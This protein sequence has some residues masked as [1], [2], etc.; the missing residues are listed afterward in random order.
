MKLVD[1]VVDIILKNIVSLFHKTLLPQSEGARAPFGN[2]A[3]PC[4]WITHVLRVL[5]ITESLF[6]FQLNQIQ[7]SK[8]KLKT[9]Y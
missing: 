8:L 1:A 4:I 7:N 3:L 2:T 5:Q 6:S 9:F